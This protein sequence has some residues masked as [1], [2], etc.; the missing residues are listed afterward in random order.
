MYTQVVTDLCKD[1]Y[2]TCV[3]QGE[4]IPGL[5]MCRKFDI[6]II[7]ADFPGPDLI[8]LLKTIILKTPEA[9]I[10]VTARP[11]SA[12]GELLLDALSAGAAE[13]MTK[14]IYD[15]YGNNLEK[16]K[17]KMTDIIKILRQRRKD[18]GDRNKSDDSEPL[19][20]QNEKSEITDTNNFYPEIVLIAASTGGPRALEIIFSKIN[21]NFPVPILI[22]QHITSPFT[23]ILA[24]R[25]NNI[26]QLNVKVAEYGEKILAGMVYFAPGG[27]HMRLDAENKIY[28]DDSPPLHGIRPAADALFESVAQEFTGQGVLTVILTGMGND[29]KE[30]LIKLKNKKNCFCISQSE[31]TCVAYGMPKAVE[32]YGLADKVMDLENISS[33]IENFNFNLKD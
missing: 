4:E 24:Q 2:I 8:V 9:F 5:L 29:G 20:L 28:F 26:S 16:I 6:I 11:S 3:T 23:G 30:G 13:C 12:N 18:A 1:A 15:S 32:E 10:L 21:S 25:L 19:N 14:P 7:D 31:R 27:M 17:Q 33:E 22:I